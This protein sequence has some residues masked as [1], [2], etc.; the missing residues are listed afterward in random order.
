MFFDF[1]SNVAAYPAWQ[2]YLR[3]YN[4]PMLVV[5][6]K[7]DQTF[8]LPEV[9]AYKRDVPNTGI[10][11]LEAGHFALDEDVNEIAADM[12]RFLA[13]TLRTKPPLPAGK[14]TV[15]KQPG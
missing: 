6:G 12:R 7:Y 14:Q 8:A 15:G 10:H 4:P 9:A 1:Q 3:Q 13:Q 5:W 2:A 11:I